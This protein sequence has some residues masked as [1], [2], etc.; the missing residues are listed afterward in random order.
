MN[1]IKS[2]EMVIKVGDFVTLKGNFGEAWRSGVVEAIRDNGSLRLG[3]CS[4]PRQDSWYRL[5][6][7][8]DIWP[9]DVATVTTRK[10]YLGY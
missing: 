3:F 5:H 8:S 4:N 6:G 10:E 2:G 7:A 9:R 1:E